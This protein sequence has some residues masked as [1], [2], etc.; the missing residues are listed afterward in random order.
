[1]EIRLTDTKARFW[2]SRRITRRAAPFS[3]FCG[4]VL[5]RSRLSVKATS[6]MMNE[7]TAMIATPRITGAYCMSV[8]A[9]PFSPSTTLPLASRRFA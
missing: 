7:Q 9:L 4:L 6:S 1:M 3:A 5:T 2:N 8:M